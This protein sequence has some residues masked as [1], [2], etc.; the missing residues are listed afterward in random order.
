MCKVKKR[1][2]G[3]DELY[4]RELLIYRSKVIGGIAIYTI[5][6]VLAVVIGT[7]NWGKLKVILF[8]DGKFQW[9][10]VTAIAAICSFL[11]TAMDNRKKL[12]SDLISK[13]RIQWLN[14][15][16]ELIAK[17]MKCQLEYRKQISDISVKI[18]EQVGILG[19]KIKGTSADVDAIG[20]EI[21]EAWSEADALKSK[22]QYFD[23]RIKL[24]FGENSY[25]GVFLNKF[26]ELVQRIN[27]LVDDLDEIAQKYDKE[28]DIDRLEDTRD[29]MFE[30]VDG[31][32]ELFVECTIISKKY[33]GLEWKKAKRGK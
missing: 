9:I 3:F 31:G 2:V 27:K 4:K 26:N 1:E 32:Q 6:F 15:T 10:A 33:F 25:N 19:W 11:F 24:Q 28:I 23:T 17:Y 22:L 12:N 13:T 20:A 30:F 18:D 29:V 8:I 7:L 21:N 14:D 16:R 5:C